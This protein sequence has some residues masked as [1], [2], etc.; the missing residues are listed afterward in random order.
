MESRYPDKR[1]YFIEYG[2][3]VLGNDESLLKRDGIVMK[4]QGNS[5]KLYIKVSLSK[6]EN[7]YDEPG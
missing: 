1:S 2:L 7:R 3:F 6:G 5:V 4:I